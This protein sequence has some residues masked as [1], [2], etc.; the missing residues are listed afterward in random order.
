M[1]ETARETHL[2]DQAIAF[3]EEMFGNFHMVY[4]MVS[5]KT[6]LAGNDLIAEVVKLMWPAVEARLERATEE[7][8]KKMGINLVAL[9]IYSIDRMHGDATG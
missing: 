8:Q 3:S 4:H 5:S 1:R 6:G 7:E 9:V 2:K